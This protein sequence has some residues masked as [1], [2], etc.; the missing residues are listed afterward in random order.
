MAASPIVPA[1]KRLGLKLKGSSTPA[2]TQN[3]TK[4]HPVIAVTS[5]K[6][7]ASGTVVIESPAARFEDT[8]PSSSKRR[9]SVKFADESKDV[10]GDENANLLS[11]YLAEQTGGEDQFS[12]AELAQFTAPVKVHAA[13]QPSTKTKTKTKAKAKSQQNGDNSRITRKERKP[14]PQPSEA[15]PKETPPYIGYLQ[16]YRDSRATWK[17][18]KNYQNALLKN[19]F[20]IFRT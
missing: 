14:R 16:N 6:R 9:K 13:N 1:W 20:N 18:S 4:S 17:F 10:D 19:I 7:K 11:N 3:E 12:Q 2:E 8:T 5:N 15:E